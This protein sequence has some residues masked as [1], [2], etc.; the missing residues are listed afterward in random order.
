MRNFN[1]GLEAACRGTDVTVEEYY[2][3]KKLVEGAISR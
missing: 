2:T 3:A 1:I